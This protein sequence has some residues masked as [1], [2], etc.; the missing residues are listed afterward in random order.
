MSNHL[1]AIIWDVDGT[2]V[3]SH[4]LCIE[5]TNKVL[6]KYLGPDAFVT[7]H[8]YHQASRFTTITRMAWHYSG[9]PDDE[10]GM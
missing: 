8:D 6:Q 10:M 9:N 5:S 4:D 1:Q 3:N 2:L 7:E